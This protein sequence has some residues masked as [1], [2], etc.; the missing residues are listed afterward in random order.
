MGVAYVNVH[1][2]RHVKEELAWAVD[3]WLQVISNTNVIKNSYT[4]K[5]LKSKPFKFK[6]V[7][8]ALPCDP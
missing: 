2:S 4:T 1:L 8:F 7:L 3:K 6:T 5:N